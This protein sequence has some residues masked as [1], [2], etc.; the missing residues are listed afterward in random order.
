MVFALPVDDLTVFDC[1]TKIPG[2]P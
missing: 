2:L 1:L